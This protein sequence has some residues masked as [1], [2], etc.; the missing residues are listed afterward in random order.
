MTPHERV[1]AD[2][3][4]TGVT[5]GPHPMALRRREMA[6]AGVTRAIDLARGAAGAPVR[7]AGSVIVRQ[8][9]GTAKGF[10]FLSLEDET[11]IANVIVTPGLFARDR[12][13]LVTEPFVLVEGILQMQDGVVSVRAQH[14][15]ALARP[16]H[17]VPSHDFG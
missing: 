8:R 9:P 16:P 11:G 1:A 13:P 12:V 2:Y 17:V 5:I 6:A 15:R 10:V 14:V 3:A 4:G 7:V